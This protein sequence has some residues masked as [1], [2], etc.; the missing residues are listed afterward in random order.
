MTHRQNW[1]WSEKKETQS[2]A[3]NPPN[4]STHTFENDI[5]NLCSNSL[6]KLIYLSIV[7][8]LGANI[9]QLL[10]QRKNEQQ[11]LLILP[12][13]FFSLRFVG[14]GHTQIENAIVASPTLAALI[15]RQ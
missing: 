2:D 13:F 3:E 1:C 11:L 6:F 8:I 5:V 15:L 10:S 7:R 9:P 14:R 12:F 4:E